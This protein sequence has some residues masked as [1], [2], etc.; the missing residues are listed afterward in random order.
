MV[1]KFSAAGEKTNRIYKAMQC[2]QSEMQDTG[3]A[4]RERTTVITGGELSS[5]KA[6]PQSHRTFG[7]LSGT[8]PNDTNYP[9]H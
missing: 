5:P 4:K 6:D 1:Q 7:K 2:F 9:F 8:K 3:T